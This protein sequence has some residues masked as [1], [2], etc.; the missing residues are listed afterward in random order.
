ML[1]TTG[2]RVET[3]PAEG[4]EGGGVGG[5]RHMASWSI[6]T[7]SFLYWAQKV[8]NVRKKHDTAVNG[9]RYD[10]ALGEGARPEYSDRLVL[11]VVLN[12][13]CTCTKKERQR[14]HL[15]ASQTAKKQKRDKTAKSMPGVRQA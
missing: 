14:R 10:R 2:A 7:R 8:Q 4:I 5:I 11:I 6:H 15:H 3:P 1:E 9:P 13:Y 12:Y